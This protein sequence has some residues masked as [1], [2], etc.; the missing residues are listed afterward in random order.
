MAGRVFILGA[1]A[2]RED[3]KDEE[4]PL[5]LAND[6][7]RSEYINQR[8]PLTDARF[9]RFSAS[10]LAV[11]LSHYFGVIIREENENII[12]EGSPNIEEVYSF[13]DSFENIYSS[14]SYQRDLF[15][16][17]K[18]ELLTYIL[19][20]ILYT[21]RTD[22]PD[23]WRLMA[24]RA[25]KKELEEVRKLREKIKKSR[26]FKTHSAVASKLNKEDSIITFNWDLLFETVLGLDERHEHYFESRNMIMNPFYGAS[27]N[28]LEYVYLKARD[29]SKGYFLKLHGSVNFA[30]CTNVDCFKN[31]FPFIIDTFDAEV[32]ELLQCNI[33]GSPI[34]I[35]IVPP[36]VNKSYKANR[37]FQL[38]ANLAADKLDVANEIIVIGYSFPE[39]D[40][41]ANALMRLAR[42][43]PKPDKDEENFLEK[44]TI[45]NPQVSEESYLDKIIDLFGL[46]LAKSAH[47]HDVDLKVYNGVDS[48][49]EKEIK[50]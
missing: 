21:P 12:V 15:S 26:P 13:L 18:K 50:N 42:L 23:F 4:L 37:F 25:T 14:V 27:K 8:W 39:F 3:T 11:I 36:N 40:F 44:V 48:Y 10:S 1:G 9:D 19:D 20:V 16:K 17:A 45:V 31:Q 32:P 49:I 7:F 2:S 46:K 43:D 5:P 28:P 24:P 38:Q 6:F 41:E 29:D 22:D 35:L 33:C 47:G 34:E 30:N